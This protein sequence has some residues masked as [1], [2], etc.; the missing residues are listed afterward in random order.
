MDNS[1]IKDTKTSINTRL[2]SPKLDAFEN[3]VPCLSTVDGTELETKSREDTV[4][5]DKKNLLSGQLSSLQQ[6]DV[7]INKPNE[8]PATNISPSYAPEQNTVKDSKRL[9]TIKGTEG[10]PV[11]KEAKRKDSRSTTNDQEERKTLHDSLPDSGPDKNDSKRHSANT[12]KGV[13]GKEAKAKDIKKTND[14]SVNKDTVDSEDAPIDTN[15][16]K[17]RGKSKDKDN[18]SDKITP[19]LLTDKI[20]NSSQDTEEEVN[21]QRSIVFSA[22]QK[23]KNTKLNMIEDSADTDHFII[24]EPG[25]KADKLSRSIRPLRSGASG[26]GLKHSSSQKSLSSSCEGGTFQGTTAPLSLSHSRLS[27]CSTVIIQ[28]ERLMLNPTKSE[29]VIINQDDYATVHE[30]EKMRIQ[31]EEGE[32]KRRQEEE[33]QR[34]QQQKEEL[35]QRMRSELQNERQRRAEENRLKKQAEDEEKQQ[36]EEEEQRR[37]QRQ[38]EQREREMGRQQERKRQIELFQRK[39]EEEEQR[40]RAETEHLKLLE[41][42]SLQE[43]NLKLQEMSVS[44]RAEYQRRKQEEED[45]R[46]REEEE[47]LRRKEEANFL[48]AEKAKIEEELLAREMALLHQRLSFKRGLVVESEGLVKS[49]GI[50]RP[51]TYS[52]FTLL[53]Q[54]DL[55]SVGERYT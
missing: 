7:T 13:K 5:K 21:K 20:T 52:Y 4:V 28:E 44:E 24:K 51:W 33:E 12:T 18:P 8:M 37:R 40:K 23:H 41:E 10:S 2:K 1:D 48:A 43:E 36:R 30:A 50:S 16:K 55:S 29:V 34:R 39:R 22:K 3:I 53:Q 15:K 14:K 47:Q 9:T 32:R 42:K 35:E 54:L 38:Q 19:D 45:K 46:E 31:G 6:E 11:S 26:S 17:R 49:Q 27:S 25:L